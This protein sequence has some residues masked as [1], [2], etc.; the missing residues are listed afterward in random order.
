M[1]ITNLLSA[2]IQKAPTWFHESIINKPRQETIQDPL[3]NLSYQVWDRENTDR[4]IVLIHGTGAHKKW[5]DPI[6]PML[7]KQSIIIAPDLPGMGESD[8]RNEYNFESFAEGIKAIL[9][10]EN[11][12][13][14]P[15]KIYLVGHSLGG[16][17]AG[18][19]ATEMPEIISGVIMIDSP[20]RPPSYDYENHLS[21]GPLRKIKY[22]EDK[23][24]ILN[25]FRLMPPQECENAWYLRY[26]AEHSVL[27]VN[28]GWRWRFDDKLFATLQRLG[29]YEFKFQCPN[30]F[31]AGGT[32][33]L[34]NSKIT[35]YIKEHFKETM[36]YE[37]IKHAAHH[38]PLDAPLELCALINKYVDRWGA[39]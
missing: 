18:F 32:S 27:E 36:S 38:V 37:V 28:E 9:I 6:A 13:A 30:L 20:I 1:E 11:S 7:D 15:K 14:E 10:K 26:I 33:L 31:I 19:I 24:S 34:L 2:D 35:E 17:V 21:T 22:Y 25:R 16:H 29:K 4:I 23:V 8:H 39:K 5:W 12:N 3:G